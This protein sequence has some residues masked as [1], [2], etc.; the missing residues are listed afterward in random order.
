MGIVP[1]HYGA[2]QYTNH[3]FELGII[4]LDG[5][6]PGKTQKI[7]WLRQVYPVLKYT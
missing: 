5:I 6:I 3:R 1:Y 2:G 7:F 4:T